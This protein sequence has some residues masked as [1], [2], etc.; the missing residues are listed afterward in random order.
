VGAIELQLVGQRAG[1]GVEV[2]CTADGRHLG[3]VRLDHEWP[4]LWTPNSAAS[5][6]AGVGRHL[7]VCD[8]YD[9]LVPFSGS[10]EGLVVE[11]HRGGA[12]DDLV[13]QVET[14]FRSQ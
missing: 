12:S 9:P 6:L 3:E 10:L 2:S 4:G 7:A 1:A 14:A 5:L 8:G 11:A 13:H